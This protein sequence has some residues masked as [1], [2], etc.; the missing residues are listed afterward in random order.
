MPHWRLGTV[1]DP[2]I[3]SVLQGSAKHNFEKCVMVEAREPCL[4]Y[5]ALQDKSSGKHEPFHLFS[6]CVAFPRCL[7]T[8][9]PLISRTGGEMTVPSCC[10]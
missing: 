3:G 1:P 6:A 2:Y 4:C 9:L 8:L 5:S 7:V 10:I